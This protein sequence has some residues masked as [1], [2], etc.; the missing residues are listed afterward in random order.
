ML[1]RHH[2]KKS[3]R[4]DK[5]LAHLELLLEG[6]AP[7]G[8]SPGLDTKDCLKGRMRENRTSG[9]VGGNRQAFHVNKYSES[10][11]ENVYSTEKMNA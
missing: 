2:Q 4:F 7:S 5:F 1:N 9:P 8:K 10:S 3:I 11:A 6:T